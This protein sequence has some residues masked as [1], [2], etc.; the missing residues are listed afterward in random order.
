MA[1]CSHLSQFFEWARRCNT[2]ELLFRLGFRTRNLNLNSCA[3]IQTSIYGV[4]NVVLAPISRL[5]ALVL[6]RTSYHGMIDRQ[7]PWSILKSSHMLSYSH[8]TIMIAIEET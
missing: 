8:I 4:R 3:R 2:E 1:S 6:L 5:L 7:Y